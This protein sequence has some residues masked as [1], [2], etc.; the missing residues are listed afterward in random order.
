MCGTHVKKHNGLFHFS[1]Q[2][3]AGIFAEFQIRTE[4]KDQPKSGVVFRLI[5]FRLR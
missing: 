1:D 3:F 4:T 2:S 5:I